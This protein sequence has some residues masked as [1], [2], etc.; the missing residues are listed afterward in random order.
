MIL[1]APR[2]VASFVLS[3]LV[4]CVGTAQSPDIDWECP[5]PRNKAADAVDNVT[6]IIEIDVEASGKLVGVALLRDPGMGFGEAAVRCAWRQPYLPHLD[7]AGAP[8]R[9][10]TNLRVRFV[11]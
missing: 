11:R 5:F 6:A 8:V 1:Q 10:K 9:A 7:D 4:S 2:L 3:A